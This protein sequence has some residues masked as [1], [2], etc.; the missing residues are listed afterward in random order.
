MNMLVAE[1]LAISPEAATVFVKRGM[2]CPGC[3]F[4]RFETV[5][6]AARAYGLNA[7]E[8]ADALALTIRSPLDGALPGS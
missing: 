7:C 1:V 5:A 4:A 3:P 6:E 2:G 8:L